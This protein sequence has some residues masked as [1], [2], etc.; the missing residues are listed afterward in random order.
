MERNPC[1]GGL[2]MVRAEGEGRLWCKPLDGGEGFG[3][4]S[5]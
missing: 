1:V 2:L 5:P 4:Y 3:N